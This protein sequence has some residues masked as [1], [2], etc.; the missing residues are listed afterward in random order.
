VTD[1]ADRVLPYV[2][3]EDYNTSNP[4]KVV[5]IVVDSEDE[6]SLGAAKV[7]PSA[8]ATSDGSNAT[9]KN[10]LRRRTKVKCVDT[11]FHAENSHIFEGG[12][13]PSPASSGS[14][15]RCRQRKCR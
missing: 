3:A 12:R 5:T 15:D 11:K 2:T 14:V 8:L 13:R 1:P 9:P 4:S 6:G 7:A 10:C